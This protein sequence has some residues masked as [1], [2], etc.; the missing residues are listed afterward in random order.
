MDQDRMEGNTMTAS[1]KRSGQRWTGKFFFALFI[2]LPVVTAFANP[3]S[4]SLF[5]TQ[6]KSSFISSERFINTN[7]NNNNNYDIEIKAAKQT[8]DKYHLIWSPTFWKKAVVSSIIYTSIQL[9]ASKSNLSGVGRISSCH[10]SK[11]TAIALPLLSSSCCA[12][13]LL[14]NALSGFGCAGFNTV[15]GPVR[16][17]LLPLLMLSTWNLL[18]QRSLGW[19]TFSLFLAFLPEL[20]YIFNSLERIQWRKQKDH[21]LLQ[22]A[23]AVTAKLQLTISNMGCIA[24]VN[25][26][27]TSIR[28]C[29]SVNS[30]IQEKSWLTEGPQK[31][32]MAELQ[33]SSP[34]TEEMDKVIQDVVIAI[35]KAGFECKIENLQIG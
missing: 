34:S 8:A 35:K 28:Q 10:Q 13:Q 21:V 14:I 33:L 19:T 16:P 11:I 27:D 9:L 29:G 15:L 25:K 7:N 26:I 20:V 23:H 22:H 4:P 1:T 6:Q 12:V 24:C 5:P 30:I 32:G 17:I 2:A 3:S 18:P 31:G